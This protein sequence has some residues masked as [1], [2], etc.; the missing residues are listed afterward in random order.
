M[1][2]QVPNIRREA[3]QSPRG[4]ITPRAIGLGTAPRGPAGRD[5]GLCAVLLS[6]LAHGALA[7]PNGHAHRIY[8]H[9]HRNSSA[10]QACAILPF[11][12]GNGTPF[13]RWAS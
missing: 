10:G 7:Y 5:C 6:R 8:H 11:N 13:C 4:G 2:T 12:P 3:E 1:A 9:A